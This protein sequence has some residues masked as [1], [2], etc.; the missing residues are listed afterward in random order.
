MFSSRE[1][2]TRVMNKNTIPEPKRPAP[3]AISRP[4]ANH[5]LEKRVIKKP[6]PPNQA[7]NAVKVMKLNGEGAW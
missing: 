2:S 7:R 3:M 6:V 5:T 1:I 4:S